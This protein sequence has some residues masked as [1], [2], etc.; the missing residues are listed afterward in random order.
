MIRQEGDR[1]Y[2]TYHLVNKDNL[3]WYDAAKIMAK[4]LGKEDAIKKI[5]TEDFYTN[6]QRPLWTPLNPTKLERAF[7]EGEKIPTFEEDI[8]K[9]LKEIGRL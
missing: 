1:V 3:T 5:T 4:H 6:L 7:G 9:Y 2:G 8:Q